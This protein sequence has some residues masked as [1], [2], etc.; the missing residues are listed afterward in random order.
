MEKKILV[1]DFDGTIVDTKSLFYKAIGDELEKFK[2]SR[3]RTEGFIDL[4]LSLRRML[5]KM[6][7][8][9][10]PRRTLKKRIWK[11]VEKH[12]SEVKKCRDIEYIKDIKTKKIIVSNS[13]K[14]FII[15]ILKHLHL[16]EYF[17]EI[18]GAESFAD[19]AEFIKAYLKEHKIK[20][21][22]CYYIG[23][24]VADVKIAEKVGCVSIIIAGKYAWD[25]KTEILK[26]E[27]DFIIENIKDLKKI[28]D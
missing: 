12:S 2:I 20:K 28:V 4:G 16:K 24:R 13:L 1:F 8:S 9:F 15:P 19:K 5:K 14:E 26:Q 6:G 23:D 25:S 11:K 21:E 27:P 22:N 3:K 17:R 10:F 7:F 18:Y